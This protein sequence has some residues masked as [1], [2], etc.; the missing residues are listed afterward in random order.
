MSRFNESEVRLLLEQHTQATGQVFDEAIFSELWQDS[1]GQP[2]LV[3]ALAYE[4]T[5]EDREARDRIGAYL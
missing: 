3:N 5:W 4:L 2:W 1:N